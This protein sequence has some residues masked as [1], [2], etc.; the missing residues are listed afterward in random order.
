MRKYRNVPTKVDGIRFDSKKEA[1]RYS[2]LKLLE[3]AGEIGLVELQPAFKIE[4]NC[5]KICT[6]IPDFAYVEHGAKIGVDGLVVRTIEDVK[7]PA[8]RKNPTYR[9]KKK[10]LEA[11]Y[12]IEIREV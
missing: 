9:L 6:V 12:G 4:I 1:A 8:T 2:E 11:V 7:S 10:L 5:K 3:K